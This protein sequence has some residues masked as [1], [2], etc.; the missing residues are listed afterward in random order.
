M[1]EL[2]DILEEMLKD[3]ETRAAYEEERAL[4][5]QEI[6]K[7]ELARSTR[8]QSKTPSVSMYV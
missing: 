2:D 6:A 4:L 3:P 1:I 8:N 5:L 7:E